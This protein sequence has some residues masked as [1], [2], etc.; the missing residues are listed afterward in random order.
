MATI[1]R[2]VFL[3]SSPDHPI[4]GYTF[5]SKW[6]I[7]RLTRSTKGDKNYA[8]GDPI[9]L[10][11]QAIQHPAGGIVSQRRVV[12]LSSRG[13]F[14]EGLKHLLADTA[15]TTTATFPQE[16]KDLMRHEKID[17]VILDQEDNSVAHSDFICELLS[18]PGTRVFT[19]GLD[20]RDIQT[21]RHEEIA[22]ASA[23]A[24]VAA[25]AS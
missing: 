2:S 6:F 22:Q 25:V 10:R 14:R 16:V 24:L 4:V 1:L 5:A 11:L 20:V 3:S 21:Y 18:S 15:V 9:S 7:I 12:I 19:V 23:E 17:T 13:L 8:I